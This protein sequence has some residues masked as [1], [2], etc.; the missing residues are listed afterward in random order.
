MAEEIKYRTELKYLIDIREYLILKSRFSA[1]FAM[2]EHTP[3]KGFYHISSLYFDDMKQTA[4]FD[5]LAGVKD[6]KKYRIRLYDHDESFIRFEKK[7]KD[8]DASYKVSAP[9][10]KAA[11]QA[12]MRGDFTDFRNSTEPLLREIYTVN[13][14]AVLRPSVITDYD[15]E[16][17]VFAPCNVRVTF[18]KNIR[19]ALESFDIFAKNLP[20]VPVIGPGQT[21]LEVKYDHA[22]PDTVKSA[23]K[24]INGIRI[25]VSKFTLCKRYDNHNDWEVERWG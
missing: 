16:A 19:T 17:F 25:A 7:V 8:N 15:R 5:K 14:A 4:Y 3:P 9:I 11:A 1:L 13:A 21:V 6:R 24:G 12:A 23:L 2:D 20:T 10:S 22:L 18:D